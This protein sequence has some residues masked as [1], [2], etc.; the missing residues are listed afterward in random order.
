MQRHLLRPVYRRIVHGLPG[1]GSPEEVA[2][3]ARARAAD[4]ESAGNRIVAG[5]IALGASQGFLFGLPGLL[6]L[7]ATLPANLAGA[8]AVQ[9]HMTASLAVLSG[10]SLDDPSVRD[11]CIDCLLRGNPGEETHDEA[12]ELAVRTT[13][14]FAERGAR[15]A[16]ER[17][18]RRSARS[19]LRR[20]GIR[21]LPLVGGLIGGVAD[22]WQTRSVAR[23]ALKEF[24][25]V[26]RPV[27]PDAPGSGMPHSTE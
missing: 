12:T 13:S 16:G 26:P 5:H 18:V 21:S 10:H 11:R 6:L 23:C 27:R 25:A 3:R 7:P 15:W 20:I 14:K 24:P 9:L 2:A 17:L 8:A 22:G 1:I 19:A 4:L